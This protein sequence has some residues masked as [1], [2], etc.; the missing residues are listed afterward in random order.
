[1][2]KFIATIPRQFTENLVPTKYE[3]MS[4]SLKSEVVTRFPIVVTIDANCQKGDEIEIIVLVADYDVTRK[5]LVIFEQDV[6]ELCERKGIKYTIKKIDIPFDESQKTHLQ[7]IKKLVDCIDDYDMLYCCITYGT[8]PT[9]LVEIYAM[10]YAKI[11]KKDISIEAIVYGEMDFETKKC[12]IFDVSAL[13]YLNSILDDAASLGTD[14]LE[15]FLSLM[16]NA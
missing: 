10:N 11:V 8:K 16:L 6:S 13:F 4:D 9:P 1:M 5:N 12:R 2:K 7:T 14:D 3:A 15:G